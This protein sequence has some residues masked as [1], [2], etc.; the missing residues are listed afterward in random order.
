MRIG[1]ALGGA[2]AHAGK[3]ACPAR[4]IS[5]P[6]TTANTGQSRTPASTD[7]PSSAT[8]TTG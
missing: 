1:F 7:P 2:C 3:Q 8:L 4:V 5:G 6:L